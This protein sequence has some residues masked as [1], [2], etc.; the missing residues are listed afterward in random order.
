M[1]VGVHI[2]EAEDQRPVTLVTALDSFPHL[3]C[4][5]CNM[6]ELSFEKQAPLT[7]D[8]KFTHDAGLGD[9]KVVSSSDSG[10]EGIIDASGIN[11]KSLLRKLDLKLLPPLSL[12]YLLSFLDRSNGMLF[13][14]LFHI[15]PDNTR[16]VMDSGKWPAD[17]VN[18]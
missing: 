13:F 8:D 16:W 1:L 3:L 18:F 12:L 9:T 11:E 5:F 7:A 4:T 2:V 10:E 14:S 17:T 15:N 6:A